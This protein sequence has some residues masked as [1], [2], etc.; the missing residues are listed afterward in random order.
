[1]GDDAMFPSG[2]RIEVKNKQHCI[3]MVI[4]QPLVYN[5]F[6]NVRICERKYLLLYDNY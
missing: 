4:T 6:Y 2:I 5:K 1:M 3:I